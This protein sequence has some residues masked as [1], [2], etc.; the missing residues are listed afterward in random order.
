MLVLVV[1]G[2]VDELRLQTQDFFAHHVL[3]GLDLVMLL[4]VVQN[5]LVLFDLEPDF[6]GVSLVKHSADLVQ[7]FEK[8]GVIEA[9]GNRVNSILE[10]LLQLFA[11]NM[12]LPL[13]N[14][15]MD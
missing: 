11:R 1:F 14:E 15:N 3:V 9:S 12:I 13:S 8:A 6:V 2:E 7:A 4:Q 10:N 5:R